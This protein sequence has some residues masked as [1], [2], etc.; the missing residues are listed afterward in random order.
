MKS[1]W[2]I[3]YIAAVV[4]IALAVPGWAA[5]AKIGYVDMQRALNE[6]ETGKKA[7]AEVKGQ[8]DKLESQLKGKKDELEK[9]KDELDRKAVVMRDEERRKMQ[10]DFERKRLDLKRKFEDAQAELQKKDNELTGSIIKELQEVI[11]Q[12]GERDR[13]TMILE[14][15]SSGLLYSD[16]STDLT[17]E[18]LAA[19]N[20]RKK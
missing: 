1:V 12:I 5:D 14:M 13:Y 3:R 16:K 17:D 8:V 15:S 11:R 9:L 20:S 6:S 19:Y 2:A 4:A 7:R 10:D 18:V